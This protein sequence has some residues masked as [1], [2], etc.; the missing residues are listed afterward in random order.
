VPLPAQIAYPFKIYAFAQDRE[1]P[2]NAGRHLDPVK[3]LMV[4]VHDPLALDTLEVMVL[5]GV[6]VE[7]PGI[8]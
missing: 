6:A 2:G 7:T 3:R 5:F 4:K 8:S 1:T